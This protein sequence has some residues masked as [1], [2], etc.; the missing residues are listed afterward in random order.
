MYNYSSYARRTVD[1]CENSE[2]LKFKAVSEERIMKL[3]AGLHSCKATGLDGLL[4]NH[5][6]PYI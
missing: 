3:L 5:C 4:D 1:K 2:E 6:Y